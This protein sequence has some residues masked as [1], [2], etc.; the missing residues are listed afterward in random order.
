ME[1]TSLAMELVYCMNG[2]NHQFLKV[3]ELA[4]EGKIT[5]EDFYDYL[6]LYPLYPDIYNEIYRDIEDA[7]EHLPGCIWSNEIKLEIFQKSEIFSKLLK[8]HEK[9]KSFN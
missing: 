2:L 5:I 7:I 3:L 1:I 4:I 8:H 9:L 6:P